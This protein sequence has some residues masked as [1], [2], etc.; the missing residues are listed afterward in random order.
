MRSTH[1]FTL[2][3]IAT[4]VAALSATAI[5]QRPDETLTVPLTYGAP[6]GPGPT[7][8]FSPKGTLVALADVPAAMTL[9]AGAARPAKQGVVKVG[10]GQS[11][12]VPILVTADAQHPSDLSHLFI[13]R[14]RNGDFGDDGAAAVATPT[15]NDKTKAW[16]SSFNKLELSIPYAGG[17][18]EPYL[19]NFWAVRDDGAPAP[20]GIRYSVGSWRSGSVT[21]DG[22][23]AL[24]A[25]MDSDNDA[26]FTKSDWWSVI[27]ADAPNAPKAVLSIAEA[28]QT[29]R[30]M[31]VKHAGAEA[32]LEFRGFS[33]DGRSITFAVV[34]RPVTK[35][36]DR[37]ADDTVAAERSRPRTS[38][39]F[40]WTKDFSA[41][42]ADAKKNNRNVIVDFWATWC[43]PC[44]TMDEWIWNDAEIAGLLNKGYVGVKLDGDLE[45]A[46]VTRFKVIGYPTMVVL[47]PSGKE[48]K[49][50]VGYQT[51]AQTL[52][53]LGK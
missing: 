16:W 46:L 30:L 11:S 50:A 15:Q 40:S 6:G 14:N 22:V 36:E 52:T 19:V 42:L 2:A 47:D 28:R 34:H 37:L 44:T 23:P 33:D 17:T 27:E 45:K 49:R 29:S 26:L 7:P 48:V 39:P 9:P 32:I 41:T 13:D 1:A 31:F 21:I 8:N 20:D 43:G 53:L 3:T 25:A 10:P 4:T 38:T 5:A 18:R 35:A 12:W 24:V 51:S